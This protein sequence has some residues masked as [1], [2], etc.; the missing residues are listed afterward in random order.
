[1]PAAETMVTARPKN[2]SGVIAEKKPVIQFRKPTCGLNSSALIPA[3][4]TPIKMKARINRPVRKFCISTSHVLQGGR[5]R[6]ITL[7]VVVPLTGSILAVGYSETRRPFASPSAD[8]RSTPPVSGS[9]L[10]IAIR[11]G[12]SVTWNGGD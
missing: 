5:G 3:E 9:G 2:L 11:C 6:Q 12:L 8:N 1:M 10:G 7:T 4:A